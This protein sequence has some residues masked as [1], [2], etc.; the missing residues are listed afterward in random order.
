MKN[1]VTRTGIKNV[2]SEKIY[3]IISVGVGLVYIMNIVRQELVVLGRDPLLLVILA[4]EN[5]E[6]RLNVKNLKI[7]G[8]V[9]LHPRIS[10]TF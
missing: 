1:T 4:L 9:I 8:Y 2:G 10:S 7:H 5:Q 6:M 3:P